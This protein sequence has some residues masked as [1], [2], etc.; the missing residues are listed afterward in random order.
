MKNKNKKTLYVDGMHCSAC[1]ILIEK[2]LLKYSNVMSVDAHL[3]E[4][5]V[6]IVFDGDKLKVEDLNIDFK[7]NGYT[8]SNNPNTKNNNV[9]FLQIINGSLVVNREKGKKWLSVLFFTSIFLIVFN[10]LNSSGFLGKVSVDSNSSMISFFSFGVLAGLSSCAALVGGLLLSMTKQWNEMYIH[11][12]SSAKKLAPFIMFNIGR[13]VSFAL[14]GGLLG[15]I[16]AKLGITFDTTNIFTS[17]IVLFISA[18]M[19]VLGLQMLGVQWAYKF[20][21]AMPKFISSRVTDTD[22]FQGKYMPFLVGALTFFVPCGFTLIAQ[23]LALT[24]GSFVQGATILFMFALGTFPILGLISLTSVNVSKK[25][26][27]NALF[28]TIAGILVVFF[29]VYNINAQLNV[30]GYWSLSDIKFQKNDVEQNDVEV[31]ENGVQIVKLIAKDFSYYP[32]T[33][34]TIKAG[35]PTK[36]IVEDQGIEGCGAFIAARGLFEGSV[37]LKRGINEIDLGKP[38]KGVYKVTCS[39]GMV[40]PVSIKVI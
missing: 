39:M 37:F 15:A 27:L 13:L 32:V 34:T 5:K 2:K 33:P 36:L 40:Y 4:G 18:I 14:L 20:K 6:E 1:E 24:S 9:P 10:Y 22:K 25:P 23:G 38:A 3:N 11:E 8:F 35:V 28:S 17:L 29:A 21:I 19:I 7:E 16:G 26:K 30:L 31:Q 12:E